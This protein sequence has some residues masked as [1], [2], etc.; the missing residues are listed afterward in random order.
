MFQTNIILYFEQITILPLAKQ[1]GYTTI[2]LVVLCTVEDQATPGCLLGTSQTQIPK[3]IL[4][5]RSLQCTQLS[6]IR[7]NRKCLKVFYGAQHY[8]MV[9]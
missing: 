7:L 9:V 5:S 8:P 1:I 2:P 4:P 6:T 3:V